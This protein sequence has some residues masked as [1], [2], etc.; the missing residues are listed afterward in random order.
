MI[1]K[2]RKITEQ[3]IKDFEEN[4]SKNK[5]GNENQLIYVWLSVSD[6]TKPYN[7]IIFFTLFLLT[8]FFSGFYF[9]LTIK[10]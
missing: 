4:V 3:F 5:L 10:L 7:K 2:R 8:V 1:A 6:K 9:G